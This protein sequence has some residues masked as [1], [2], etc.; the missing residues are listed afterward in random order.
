M[1]DDHP[2]VKPDIMD[3]EQM[4]HPRAHNVS[5][6]DKENISKAVEYI[7]YLEVENAILKGAVMALEEA[8]AKC[9]SRHY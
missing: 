6:K 5:I 2:I 7:R 1:P 3:L 4:S 8:H 9:L